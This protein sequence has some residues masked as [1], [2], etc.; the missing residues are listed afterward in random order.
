M[1]QSPMVAAR[2]V[3]RMSG[4]YRWG[5]ISQRDVWGIVGRRGSR[6]VGADRGVLSRERFVRSGDG[7]CGREF[8]HGPVR[9]ANAVVNHYTYLACHGFLC[10]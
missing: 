5:A 3:Q 8:T 4:V 6:A 10:R 1:D 7:N 2:F 9:Q